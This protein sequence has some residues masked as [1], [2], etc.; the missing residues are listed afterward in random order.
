MSQITPVP[1]VFNLELNGGGDVAMLDIRGENF[2]TFLRVW[3][4][5]VEADTMYRCEDALLCVVPDIR[6]FK[7]GDKHLKLT[8]PVSLVRYDGVIYPTGHTFTYTP[9]PIEKI[10]AE[11]EMMVS[12]TQKG[13][14]HLDC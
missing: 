6:L 12:Q 3:F 2:T 1:L 10:E 13:V 7:G 14:V 4:G 8:V 9:E 5:D 11:V